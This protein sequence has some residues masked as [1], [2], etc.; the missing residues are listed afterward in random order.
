M[1]S[2]KPLKTEIL[3]FKNGTK[4]AIVKIYNKNKKIFLVHL[5]LS[6]RVREKQFEELKKLIDKKSII[7]GDFNTFSEKEIEKTLEITKMKIA[8]KKENKTFPAHNP[9]KR[10]DLCFIQKE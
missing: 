2:K 7:I 5:S 3:Y 6:K 10:L 9:K 4:R 8:N 1:L